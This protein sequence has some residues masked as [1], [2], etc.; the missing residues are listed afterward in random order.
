MMV[1]AKAQARMMP[2]TSVPPQPDPDLPLIQGI[3]RGDGRSLTE[4]YTRHG[5]NVLNYLTSYLDDRQL[6]EEVLQDVMLAVWNHAANFRGESKVRTWLLTIARNRAINASRR[7]TPHMVEL[8]ENFHT[9]D[10]SPLE[11]AEAKTQQ[12]ALREALRSLPKFHQEILVLVFYHGL[13]GQETAEVLGVS[14]GT[15]K[16][17]LHRAKEMLKRVLQSSGDEW[18][19]MFNA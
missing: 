16:S 19:E 6:A 13:S 3:A 2:F 15:V 11:R 5:A 17:R 9:G 8:D 18:G 14:V 7:Y 1:S 12:Q 4:L 10:T